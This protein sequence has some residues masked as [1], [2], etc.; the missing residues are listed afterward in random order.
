MGPTVGEEVLTDLDFAGDLA[1]ALMTGVVL[2]V[3][4]LALDTS[5]DQ[6][7]CPFGLE[8]NWTRTNIQTTVDVPHNYCHIQVA[9][10]STQSIKL[11][12]STIL[13]AT[14]IELG[15]ARRKC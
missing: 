2:E 11:M 13:T 14:V 15:E 5:M 12:C 6:E 4:S 10:N 7:T 8:V 9:G 3:L 1:V